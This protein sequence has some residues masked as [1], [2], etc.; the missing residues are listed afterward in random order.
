VYK[1][2]SPDSDVGEGACTDQAAEAE[3]QD[4]NDALE[5]NEVV[6]VMPS[7]SSPM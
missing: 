6:G 4:A 7:W 1:T 5:V 3:D 2:R